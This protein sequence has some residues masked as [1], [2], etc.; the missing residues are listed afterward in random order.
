VRMFGVGGVN[1]RIPPSTAAFAFLEFETS[2]QNH[3]SLEQDYQIT[4]GER[5]IIKS[6][7]RSRDRL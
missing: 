3:H 5:R 4:K 7:Q 2:L 1:R 6:S